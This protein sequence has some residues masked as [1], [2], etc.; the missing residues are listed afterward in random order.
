MDTVLADLREA[1]GAAKVC[2]SRDCK[3]DETSQ[4]LLRLVKQSLD[5]LL[6]GCNREPLV[7]RVS[8]KEYFAFS[9]KGS[10]A[11]ISRPANAALFELDLPSLERRWSQWASGDE[12]TEG[13]AGLSYT[14]ALA[15]CLAMEVFDRQNKKGPATYFECFIGHL[16]AKVLETN[17]RK[18]ASF[19]VEGRTIR[20]TMDFIFDLEAGGGVRVH[21]PVKMSTRERVVQAWAHQRML[22]AAYGVGEYKGIMV[23]FSETKLDLRNRE[24]IEI[25]VPDQWL[26]YQ[27]LLSRMTRIYYFDMPQRYQDLT[28]AHPDA[29]QIR[30]FGEFFKEKDAVLFE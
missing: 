12:T 24:V 23:L 6:T 21:L 28:D 13:L 2:T 10:P 4:S 11:V 7:S 19:R 27:V 8:G 3:S 22:D 14:M 1:Y 17:P 26:A 20:M 5:F 29:I 15:P 30:Q 25:C 16:F 18:Q 9:R